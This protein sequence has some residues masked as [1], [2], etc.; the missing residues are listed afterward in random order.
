MKNIFLGLLL[1]ATMNVMAV[2]TA[3][4]ELEITGGGKGCKLTLVQDDEATA[5]AST[6]SAEINFTNRPVA[7]FAING[8]YY[9]QIY[10]TNDLEG[11][12]LGLT[13]NAATEYT[14]KVLNAT[15][16]TI[17][18]KDVVED[19]EMALEKN[20]T[21]TITTTANRSNTNPITERFLLTTVAPAPVAPEICHRY[22]KLEIR[23]SKG[24]TVQV[25]NLNGTPTS[26]ADVTLAT[27]NETIDLAGLEEGGKYLV[28]WN[29]KDLVILP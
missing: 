28:K 1:A 21:K 20:A 15:G 18:L 22:G 8:G 6:G 17:T 9:Y 7:L 23:G 4:V 11:L 2:E 29:G 5:G 16:N 19:W 10:K 3:R 27:D 26:V 14:F 24:M 13:T 25:L 12:S